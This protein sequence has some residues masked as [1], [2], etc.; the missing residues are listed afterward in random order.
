MRKSEAGVRTFAHLELS[1]NVRGCVRVL[2]CGIA[3]SA[4]VDIRSTCAN[5]AVGKI[6]KKKYRKKREKRK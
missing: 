6:E 4:C 3:Q 1:S 5:G 2:V